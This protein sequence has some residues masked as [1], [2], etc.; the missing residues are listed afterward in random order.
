MIMSEYMKKITVVCAFLCVYVFAM[1]QDS[2]TDV[3]VPPVEPGVRA[4]IEK[5]QELKF[6]LFIHWGIYSQLGCVES[7]SLVPGDIDWQMRSR[8]E[9]G[10]TY[11]EYLKFYEQTKTTFNPLD[12]DPSKWAAAA[13]YAGMKYVIFTTKHHD[14]FCMFDTDQTDYKITSP[15]C[16]FHK[17]PRA[18][19]AKEIFDAFRAEDFMT[20]A[21]F[22]VPDWHNDDYWWRMFP[23]K[24]TAP[25][26]DAVRHPEK[27]EAY[28]NF[29]NAQID[30]LTDGTYGEIPLLWLDLAT[31]PGESGAV[32]DWERA[33]KT[34]R[35]NQQNAMMVARGIHGI[36]ENYRTPEQEM[37]D[38]ALDYPWES[39]YT[40]TYSWAY[41]PGLEYKTTRTI[42]GMLVKIV[43]RGGNF[44]LNVGPK[45]D[46][47]LED[48]A[49]ERLHDIG[50]WMQIN[51]EGIYG[52][53]PIAPYQVG[54]VYFS[55]KGD[56][57][58]AFYIAPEEEDS[59]PETINIGDFIPSGRVTML[60]TKNAL[61]WKKTPEGTVVTIP[62]SLR[63]ALPCDYIWCLKFTM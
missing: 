11:F 50:D 9:R 20:G 42:L 5:W 27:W 25:N 8:R 48:I 23:P 1:A 7:W 10:M 4:T 14:G 44:L 31:A 49:Y 41:R 19:I 35:N 26:Y 53:R 18:N 58:Y 33:A 60:G 3:Y 62:A 39:C 37:P 15:Q 56:S 43:T 51:S 63:K 45:P 28:Q 47:T 30:E 38:K 24:S 21:Y 29:F 55:R 54:D 17:S 46:G 12:F 52:T 6:G 59:I 57:V 22:S 2:K 40:M 61:S 34:L 36:Y 32:V 16:P 13:K